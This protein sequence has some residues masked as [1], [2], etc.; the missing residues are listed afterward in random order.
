MRVIDIN[1]KE[2]V[3]ES[4]YKIF[5]DIPSAIS[6]E[7]IKVPYI[8]VIVKGGQSTWTEW[9]PFEDFKEKNPGMLVKLKP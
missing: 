1:G 2:R 5:H 4:I 8:E 7:I 6:D 9:W 3:I